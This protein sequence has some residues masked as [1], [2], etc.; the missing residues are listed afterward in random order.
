MLR[1]YIASYAASLPIQA[2]AANSGGGGNSLSSRMSDSKFSEGAAGCDGTIVV[3]ASDGIGGMNSC[4]KSWGIVRSRTGTSTPRY[5]IQPSIG[6]Q[7]GGQSC[8]PL[9]MG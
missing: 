8:N 3:L 5:V 9:A 2:F 6:N 7:F 4:E 1:W